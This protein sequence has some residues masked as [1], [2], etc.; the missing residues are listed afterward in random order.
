MKHFL[1]KIK[2][3]NEVV[4]SMRD[5]PQDWYKN[6]FKVFNEKTQSYVWYSNE[7]YGLQFIHNGVEYYGRDVTFISSLFG[8]MMPWRWKLVNAC[9][10]ILPFD[11]HEA[12]NWWEISE[13][14]CNSAKK[15]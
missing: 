1:K 7:C 3:I 10:Y 11:I 6:E 8:W 13:A 15:I 12:D 2:A 14:I 9:K 4:Q 5:N